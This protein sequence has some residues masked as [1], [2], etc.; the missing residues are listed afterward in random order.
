MLQHTAV[1]ILHN[2]GTR[3]WLTSC[4]PPSSCTRG[5]RAP[6]PRWTRAWPGPRPGRGRSAA[7]RPAP[8]SP[9]G[10]CPAPAAQSRSSCPCGPGTYTQVCH[11]CLLWLSVRYGTTMNMAFRF[12]LAF[13]LNEESSLTKQAVSTCPRCPSPRICR[14]CRS[15]HRSG[16]IPCSCPRSWPDGR[17]SGCSA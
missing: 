15:S 11:F 4:S 6:T 17:S 14:I 5:P 2:P 7:P 9:A 3:S 16:R 10:S 8:R 1:T 12:S 13:S